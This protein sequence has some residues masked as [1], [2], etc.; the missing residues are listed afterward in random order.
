MPYWHPPPP[1]SNLLLLCCSVR[2]FDASFLS[3]LLVSFRC[4]AAA[5]ALPKLSIDPLSR[6]N[7]QLH[8]IGILSLSILRVSSLLLLGLFPSGKAS[9]SSSATAWILM[10]NPCFSRC[11]SIP[12]FHDFSRSAPRFGWLSICH[13]FVCFCIL[14]TPCTCPTCNFVYRDH[15]CVG[16]HPH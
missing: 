4:F 13:D 11:F 7:L 6:C 2:L 10:V 15:A 9:V 14:N 16:F 1:P 5:L 12:I 3:F 8:P